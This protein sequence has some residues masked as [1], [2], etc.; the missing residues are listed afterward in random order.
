MSNL[1]QRRYLNCPYNR[2]RELLASA[3]QAAATSGDS[4]VLRLRLPVSDEAALSKDV[5][6]SFAPGR[7]PMHFDQPWT[8]TWEPSGGGLYPA[9]RGTLTVRADE[10]YHTSMLELSG[11]YEP[12][13]GAVGA[14]FDAVVGSRIAHGTARE[15]LRTIGS[16]IEVNYRSSEAEKTASR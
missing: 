4:E 15:L 11:V 14:V 9:F 12:P 1:Y 6:I 7:D 10:S 13:L 2:A 3:V 16:E 5:W 8:V